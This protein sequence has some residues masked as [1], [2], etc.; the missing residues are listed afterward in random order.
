MAIVGVSVRTRRRQNKETIMQAM[1]DRNAPPIVNDTPFG[2]IEYVI[3]EWTLG[4]CLVAKSD[5]GV[6]AVLFGNDA[7]VLCAD[8]A[9]RF[10]NASVKHGGGEVAALADRVMR[11]VESPLTG[12]DVPVAVRGTA[13]Q[14]SVWQALRQIPPGSTASYTEIARN[15]GRPDAVRA[16]ARACGANALAVVIPCHRVVRI[17]GGLS[18]Y[19]WGIERKRTLLERESGRPIV[20]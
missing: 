16:V 18:G 2:E 12:L 4:Q 20:A 15:I 10:P 1:A 11:F 14:Q 8:V 6:C 3:R 17:D 5:A 13:F 9:A 7:E 19:R